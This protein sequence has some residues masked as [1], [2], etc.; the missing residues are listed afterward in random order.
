MYTIQNRL[1]ALVACGFASLIPLGMLTTH[2]LLSHL[3]ALTE[4]FPS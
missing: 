2:W 3:V 4:N 1:A